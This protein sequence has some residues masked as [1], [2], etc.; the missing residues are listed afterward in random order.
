VIVSLNEVVA[1][2]HREMEPSIIRVKVPV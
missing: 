1:G 2:T